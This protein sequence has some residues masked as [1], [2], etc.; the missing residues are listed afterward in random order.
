M[1]DE[2]RS[3]DCGV[4]R[5]VD[6]VGFGCETDVDT[7]VFIIGY[8]SRSLSVGARSVLLAFISRLVGAC[9]ADGDDHD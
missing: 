2:G 3:I 6:G 7:A 4:E 8:G 5:R 9:N 1:S